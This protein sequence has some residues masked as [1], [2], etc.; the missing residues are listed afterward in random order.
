MFLLLFGSVCSFAQS[1][2]TMNGWQFHEYDIPK[3]EKAIEKAP[4][5]GVNFFIFS[6]RLFRSVDGFLVSGKDFNPEKKYPNLSK[7]YSQSD[8]HTKPHAG[9]QRDLKYLA[10]LAAKEKIPYYLWV[11]EF[12]DIPAEFKIGRKVNFDD[13]GL[14]T[15]VRKRYEKLLQVMPDCEGFVLTLHESD[16][17]V[18]RNSEV[19]SKLDVPERIYRLTKLIYDVLKE[20]KKKLILRSFFYEPKE[21]EYFRTALAKLPDDIIVMSKTT[22][23]EFDPFYPPDNMHGSLGKKKQI[24]EIDLGVE[25]ALGSEGAYAQTEYIQKY[26]RRARDLGLAGMVGRARLIWDR[27]F[28]DSHEINLYAFSRFMKDPNLT[29]KEVMADWAKK[30]YNKF[31]APYIT[32]AMLRTQYI[33][34][35]GRY[36]LGFWLTKSIGSGWGDYRYYFGHLLE[37]SKNKWTKNHADKEME[38][39]LYHPDADVYN[40][41]IAEKNEV[42]NKVKESMKDIDRASRYLSPEK[43][44]PLKKEFNFLMDAAQLERE[45]T[46]AYFSMRMYTD[47]PKPEYKMRAENAL[48]RLYKMDRMPGVF[49]GLN[50]KTGHRYDIDK[51]ILEMKWRMVNRSRAREEDKNILKNIYDKMNVGIN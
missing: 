30:R 19:I 1:N 48:A 7:L 23:H 3:L 51:F 42:I 10:S 25:K 45:W 29:V 50:T 16:N 6:H 8:E 46:A 31:A 32:S 35:H 38:N 34:H 2:F 44:E 18:F 43:I 33:N 49:Y 37:R 11:H 24:I 41:L 47:D 21:M 20:H 17:K 27:P 12:D 14:F 13:P 4:E 9:W 40:K 5:Y 15:Y 26:A 39:K 36:F 22:F 28:E